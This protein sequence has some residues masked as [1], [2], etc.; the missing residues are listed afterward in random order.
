M[1]DQYAIS[2][3]SVSLTLMLGV[4]GSMEM[5]FLSKLGVIL[6]IIFVGQC[7]LSIELAGA[8]RLIPFFDEFSVK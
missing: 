6:Y 1:C 4:A 5:I 3:Q 8:Q 7:L 2:I